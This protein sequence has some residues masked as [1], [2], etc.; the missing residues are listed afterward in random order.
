MVSNIVVAVGFRQSLPGFRLGG[1][2]VATFDRTGV[3]GS[4]PFSD[5]RLN[6]IRN[7]ASDCS[8]RAIGA[9]NHT[10]QCLLL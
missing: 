10:S 2:D 7:V 9:I 8:V 5:G 3:L 4:H 6:S 1:G